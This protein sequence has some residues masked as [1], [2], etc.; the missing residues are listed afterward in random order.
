MRLTRLR[1]DIWELLHIFVTSEHKVIPRKL[2][3]RIEALYSHIVK[4]QQLEKLY[5]GGAWK[6]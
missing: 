1:N 3:L 2:Y 5:R 4:I 6:K